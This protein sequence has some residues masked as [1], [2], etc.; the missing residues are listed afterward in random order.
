MAI[1]RHSAAFYVIST[2][3]NAAT[4]AFNA[5]KTTFNVVKTSFFPASQRH[6][7]DVRWGAKAEGNARRSE[8]TRDDDGNAA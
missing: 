8:A 4:T 5:T 1:I 3:F 7:G 2:A 6:Y